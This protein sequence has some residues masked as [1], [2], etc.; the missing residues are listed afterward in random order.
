MS[1]NT[2]IKWG[3]FAEVLRLLKVLFGVQ[4]GSSHDLVHLVQPVS[5]SVGPQHHPL[6]PRRQTRI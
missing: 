6:G 1:V 3:N 4:G 2:F 5:G